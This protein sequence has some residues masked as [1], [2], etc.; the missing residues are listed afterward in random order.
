MCWLND[1][2]LWWPAAAYPEDRSTLHIPEYLWCDPVWI[3]VSNFM[4]C[5][6]WRMPHFMMGEVNIDSSMTKLCGVGYG[7]CHIWSQYRHMLNTAVNCRRYYYASKNVAGWKYIAGIGDNL[8]PSTSTPVWTRLRD[9]VLSSVHTC[10]RRQFVKG[11]GDDKLSPSRRHF[12]PLCA[13]LMW[14]H[15]EYMLWSWS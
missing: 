7:G 3:E 11:S 9:F 8:S 5:R 2:S 6:V 12:L 15:F 4:W 14:H 10:I 1:G 13:R